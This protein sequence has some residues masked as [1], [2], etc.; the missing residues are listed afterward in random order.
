[1]L[2]VGDCCSPIHQQLFMEEKK[3]AVNHTA[4]ALPT[5]SSLLQ[6]INTW[7]CLFPD[8][9]WV[10]KKVVQLASE[11][12]ASPRVTGKTPLRRQSLNRQ[13]NGEDVY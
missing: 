5:W 10:R 12:R 6:E 9:T 2:A 11:V 7:R 8:L 1:M 4:K 13:L 3:V